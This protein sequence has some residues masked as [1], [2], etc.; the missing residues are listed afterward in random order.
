M[1]ADTYHGAPC[2]HGHTLR[3][4]SNRKCVECARVPAR[5]IVFDGEHYVSGIHD[6]LEAAQHDAYQLTEGSIWLA[7]KV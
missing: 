4:R 3:Y 1:T 7:R 5:Y 6:S 2:A